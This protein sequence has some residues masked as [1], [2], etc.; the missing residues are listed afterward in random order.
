MKFVFHFLAAL[1]VSTA[2]YAGCPVPNPNL[3]APPFVDGCALPAVALNNLFNQSLGITPQGYGGVGNGIADDTT[4]VTR[5]GAAAESGTAT[6]ILPPGKL[7]KTTTPIVFA[8]PINIQGSNQV[9]SQYASGCVAGIINETNTSI[10]TVQGDG[11][12]VIAVCIQAGASSTSNATAGSALTAGGTSSAGAGH[13]EIAWNTIYWPYNGIAIG[14]NTTGTT[15]TSSPSIH[16]NYVMG[17]ANYAYSIGHASSGASTNDDNFIDNRADC[18]GTGT[19][20]QTSG[21]GVAIFDGGIA[22]YAGNDSYNYNVGFAVEPGTANATG[23]IVLGFFS[24]TLGD[25]SNTNNV[26]I[27][28]TTSL[29]GVEYLIFDRWWA[30]NPGSGANV[31]V[32]DTGGGAGRVHGITFSN[33]IV[34]GGVGTSSCLIDLENDVYDITIVGNQI[35]ADTNTTAGDTGFCDN[36]TGVVGVE[37]GLVFDSNNLT[38]NLGTLATGFEIGSSA[39]DVG[40][41][42]HNNFSNATTPGTFNPTS[43]TFRMQFTNN[44]PFA[45]NVETLADAAS[46]NIGLYDTTL[47]TGTGTS[48]TSM[49]PVWGSR[50]V[51]LYSNNSSGITTTTGGTFPFCL[52]TNQVQTTAYRYKWNLAVPC[53]QL[54]N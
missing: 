16:N 47:V 39:G 46:I 19:A 11:S 18:V 24:D 7:Y 41:I 44:F 14:G 23:Q 31:L 3:L 10:L 27:N 49:S 6:L 42:S 17:G 38:P 53:W 26:L 9:Y 20:C 8:G 28:A 13:Q 43:A 33:G 22:H 45:S 50:E 15:Q 30:G 12:K 37:Q 1:V 52:S 32:E 2:A 36:S 4:A 48:I 35:A 51:T 40:D 54:V 5:A 29:G 25:T 34:H 21:T